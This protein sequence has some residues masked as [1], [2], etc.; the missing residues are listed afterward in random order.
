MIALA[1]Q[2]FDLEGSVILSTT[3]FDSDISSTARRI[4]RTATLDGGSVIT[5]GGY[6]A[7]DKVLSIAAENVDDATFQ[8]V[9]YLV[10]NYSQIIV[11]T[12]FGC[13]VGAPETLTIVEGKLRLRVLVTEE[14]SD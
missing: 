4:S 7:A 14:I 2:T 10:K 12:E 1:T 8:A 5:D 3:R 6:T 11:S 13:Y 9:A